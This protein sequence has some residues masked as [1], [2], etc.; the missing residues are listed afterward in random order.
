MGRV[1]GQGQTELTTGVPH[2]LRIEHDPVTK[3][4]YLYHANNDAKIIK[5]KLDGSVIRTTSL[6]SWQKEKP[7]YWPIKPCD[8]IV[9]PGTDTLLVADGYGSSFIHAFNKK[10]GQYMEGKTFGGKGASTS[11]PIKFNTPHGIN[12]DPR[13]P[14]TLV[15]SD[16]SNNRLVWITP[17]GK[18]VATIPT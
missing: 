1:H 7:Q 9:V 2:G 5:T 17:E 12:V 15:V 18:Y 8:A 16:R 13:R 6:K 10:T 4:S 11:D 14:G 3:E